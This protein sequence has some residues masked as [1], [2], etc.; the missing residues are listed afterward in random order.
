[1]RNVNRA[2]LLLA[3]L[4]FVAC[5]DRPYEPEGVMDP[6]LAKGGK[7]DKPGDGGEEPVE[8]E[9]VYVGKPKGKLALMSMAADGSGKTVIWTCPSGCWR[10]KWSPDGSRIAFEADH[11]GGNDWFGKSLYTVGS[12]GSGL[13]RLTDYD[14][15][16]GDVEWSPDGSQLMFTRADPVT[17]QVSLFT[18]NA[19][20][21]GIA[22]LPGVFP[23]HRESADWS[24]DG[25]Q[26]VFAGETEAGEAGIYIA[27]ADGSGATRITAPVP[28]CPADP[29]WPEWTDSR[30]QW[31]PDGSWIAVARD[32]RCDPEGEKDIVLIRPDGSDEVNITADL[33][34][35]TQPRWSPDGSQLVYDGGDW[36]IHVVNVDGSGH[37]TIIRSGK[38]T[39]GDPDWKP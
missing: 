32:D 33:A 20:G 17:Y 2:I 23:H 37:V 1:M 11:D 13:V 27:N 39:A 10:P 36:S 19:D 9:I 24:P 4:L 30:P 28:A 34:Y 12:D 38:R 26:I 5:E 3:T 6:V 29:Q 15:P 31:S 22:Q 25:S 21:S 8:A 16:E 35:A 7:P 18:V 14:G